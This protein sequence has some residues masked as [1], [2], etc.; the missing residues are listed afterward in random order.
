MNRVEDG[1]VVSW[2]ADLIDFIDLIPTQEDA[3]FVLLGHWLWAE[4]RFSVV[5]S[6]ATCI[7]V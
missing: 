1:I 3:F 2:T 7:L 6:R 4:A 5:R